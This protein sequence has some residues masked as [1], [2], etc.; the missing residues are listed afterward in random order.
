MWA[1]DISI[2]Q[3]LEAK[4]DPNQLQRCFSIT[5]TNYIYAFSLH[6]YPKR[7][8]VHSGYTFFRHYVILLEQFTSDAHLWLTGKTQKL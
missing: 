2:G 3:F 8:T 5:F 6:F 4:T 1:Q 7:L